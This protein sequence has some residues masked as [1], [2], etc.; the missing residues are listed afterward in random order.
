[1]NTV[2]LRRHYTLHLSDVSFTWKIPNICYFLCF[3]RICW[4][5]MSRPGVTLEDSVVVCRKVSDNTWLW[6]G[7]GRQIRA[8]WL[9]WLLCAHSVIMPGA[10]C[11]WHCQAS[12]LGVCEHPVVA[13][14]RASFCFSW[15]PDGRFRYVS[16]CLWTRAVTGAAKQAASTKL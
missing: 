2:V 16:Y 14:G 15:Q 11:D 13:A 3:V 7:A 6:G 10:G 12:G 1:M 4:S 5:S 8:G 9:K